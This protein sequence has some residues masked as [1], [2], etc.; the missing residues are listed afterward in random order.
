MVKKNGLPKDL[1]R[2]ESRLKTV[3]HPVQPPLD[4]VEDLRLR[5]DREMSSKMKSKKVKTGLL[6]AGGI[7][8]LAVMVV[9]LIRSLMTWPSV[10][11][12]LAGKFRKREPV[13]TI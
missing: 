7:V 2:V 5:L 12:S 8:G 4:F 10:V 11:Q 1:V 6:V 3:L 13:A 9:T